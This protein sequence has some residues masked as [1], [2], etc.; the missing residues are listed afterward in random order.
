MRLAAAVLFVALTL[1]GA[2]AAAATAGD[3]TRL[4]VRIVHAHGKFLLLWF[5]C[6]EGIGPL[7]PTI[8]DKLS[9]DGVET[10]VPDIANSLFLPATPASLNKIPDAAIADMIARAVAT[11][12]QVVIMAAG[13]ATRNVLRG[14]RLW[15]QRQS[16]ATPS[17]L[18]GAIL[19]YPHIYTGHPLPGTPSP[20][21]PITHSTRLPIVILQPERDPAKWWVHRLELLLKNGG[22]QVETINLPGMRDAFYLRHDQ[23]KAEQRTTQQ[24]PA[25]LLN[26]FHVLRKLREEMSH[27]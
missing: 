25:I 15:Q 27:D 21:A 6:F 5:P 8:L 3:D 18:A 16:T 23:T 10:W 12:K 17:R 11:H 26:A 9:R 2:S 13:R 1:F 7:G 19:L 20:Y 24:L 22:S 14:V 4:S